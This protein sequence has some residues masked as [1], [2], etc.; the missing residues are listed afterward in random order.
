MHLRNWPTRGLDRKTS[1]FKH[2]HHWPSQ[3][4]TVSLVLLQMMITLSSLQDQLSS[5]N[6]RMAH[7]R[8]TTALPPLTKGQ[9]C[10]HFRSITGAAFNMATT[11]VLLMVWNRPT[12]TAD[13]LVPGMSAADFPLDDPTCWKPA[14]MGCLSCMTS[15]WAP[16]SCMKNLQ[17]PIQ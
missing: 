2:W 10:L 14:M 8:K 5:I 13:Y 12:S 17:A 9:R 7:S 15:L 6:W 11:R 3:A 1:Q 16:H 4:S